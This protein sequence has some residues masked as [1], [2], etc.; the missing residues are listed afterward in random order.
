MSSAA[1]SAFILLANQLQRLR[2]GAHELPSQ[3]DLVQYWSGVG[4]VLDGVHYVAPRDEVA[5]VLSIPEYTRIPGVYSWMKGVSNVRGRLMAVMDL[6]IFF[7][8][9]SSLKEQRRRLLVIDDHDIY[10]G[11]AVDE[12]LGMQHFPQHDHVDEWSSVDEQMAP[13]ITGAYVRDGE[14]WP[15]FSLRLLAEDPRFLQVSR[16]G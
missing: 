3:Q 12:I 5:E 2:E 15:V 8:K 10:T 1:T 16:A 4:F 6:T 13:Y 7:N 9:I 14:Y 11:M